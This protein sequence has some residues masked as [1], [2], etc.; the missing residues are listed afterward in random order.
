MTLPK[1]TKRESSWLY[2]TKDDVYKTMIRFEEFFLRVTNVLNWLKNVQSKRER[3]RHNANLA[4]SFDQQKISRRPRETKQKEDANGV[5]NTLDRCPALCFG[6]LLDPTG[7]VGRQNEPTNHQDEDDNIGYQNDRHWD[8]ETADLRPHLK[9][10]S[11]KER[12]M[13]LC[14]RGL[15]VRV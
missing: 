10:A 13:R 11:K 4:Y 9:E 14:V 2:I 15:F 3:K 8:Q 6:V 7:K 5:L 12:L 1:P